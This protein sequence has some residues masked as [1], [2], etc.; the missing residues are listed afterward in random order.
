VAVLTGVLTAAVVY[1]VFERLLDT[2][3]PRGLLF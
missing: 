2:P 1:V 3:F